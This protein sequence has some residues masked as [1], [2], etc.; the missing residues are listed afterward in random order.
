MLPAKKTICLKS[1]F[2]LLTLVLF[3]SPILKGQEYK[4]TVQP[5]TAKSM[6]GYVYDVSKD[7]SGNTNITYK[8][9]LD[10]KSEAVSFEKYS[11]DKDIKFISTTDVQEIKEQK[12][13]VERTYLYAYVGGTSSFDVTSMKLKLNKVVRLNTWN[14]EKQIYVAKKYISNE[15][16]KP[17][18][19]AGKVY[20]G[21]SSYNSEDET[22]P[23]VFILA[24]TESK[25][26]TETD[27][28]YVLMLNDKLEL[29]EIPLELNGSY[30]LV[31]CA[32]V[33]NENVVMIFAPNKGSSDVT[34]YSYFQFDITGKLIDKTTF[35]SPASALLITAASEMQ[36]NIYFCG[37]STKTSD[38]YDEVFH[39][40]A[41]IYNPG[42][43][44]GGNNLADIKWRKALDEK[45][46][47]FHLLKFSGSQ[48]A[49][50]S[51]TPISD[52]KTKFKTA[53]DD[54][55]ASAYKGK[56]FFIEKFYITTAEE[57]L[58]AGQLSE[59]VSLGT[60]NSVDA[61]EDIVCFHFDK[62]GKLKAQYGIGKVNSDKKSEIF[63]MTQQFYPSTD[64]KSLYWELMEVKGT[65]GYE[66]F[67]DAYSGSPSFYPLYFPRIV[68]IDLG[69]SSMGPVKIMGEE[70]YFL[71]RDFT[72]QFDKTEN[73]I[74]YVGHDEDWKKIWL[75]KVML[76]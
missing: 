14:H 36:G 56:Q 6:K 5:L 60:G 18:N 38:P 62:G 16:I 9:K 20:Y 52:F 70:K 51:T 55:G 2:S 27:K 71:R 63:S 50:S 73:S 24:K 15:T 17:K 48:L 54:K 30:S 57:Y 4:E 75:G 46:E 33:K 11:F 3:A 69:A 53:P 28:F 59:R 31:F 43:T 64:G 72:S 76:N 41:P 67:M 10:K 26:K 19:D 7:L 44:P 39:E 37:T 29:T 21:Y 49:F 45:M 32:Q 13:D 22:K 40:Y 68:K 65:K 1:I 25:V 42:N 35:T 12:A 47:N 66:S 74:T 58:I 34:K 23:D 8:M 61:Y